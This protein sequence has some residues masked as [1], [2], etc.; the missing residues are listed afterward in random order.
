MNRSLLSMYLKVFKNAK[1]LDMIVLKLKNVPPYCLHVCLFVFRD[2]RDS[3]VVVEGRF[4]HISITS[5]KAKFSCREIFPAANNMAWKHKE[6]HP[7]PLGR[8]HTIYSSKVKN[9]MSAR[10]FRLSQTSKYLGI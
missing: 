8:E 2:D 5:K 10:N 1:I 3:V 4:P 6:S 7:S 9:S